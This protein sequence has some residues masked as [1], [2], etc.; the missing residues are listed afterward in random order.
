MIAI[1]TIFASISI[2]LLITPFVQH[3]GWQLGCVD[4]PG[5]RKTHQAP[6]VRIG[7]VAICAGT[8]GALLVT[9]QIG[10]FNGLLPSE[11][12]PILGLILGGFGFFSVGIA[13]DYLNLHP[14]IR[15]L[16]QA[17]I[18]TVVWTMGVQIDYLPIPIV[19][20]VATGLFG[21]PIT[22]LWLAGMANAIN[23]MDGLD[24]LA[25]GISAIVALTL[26]LCCFQFHHDA[27]ALIALAL[28]GAT[29]GFLRYN[30]NP[31]QIYMGDGGSYF[32]GF[33]LAGI[34]TVGFMQTDALTM[35][36]VPYIALAVPVLDMIFVIIARLIDGKSP[37]FA[38]LRHLHHR[39][40]QAGLSQQAVVWLIYGI[41]LCTALATIAVPMNSFGWMIGASTLLVLCLTNWRPGVPLTIIPQ[42]R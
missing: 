36:L 18:S 31:A 26:A 39:W 32:L 13:D 17:M 11:I 37:L 25:A 22:F 33:M 41:T 35:T 19:G 1:I 40:L 23:W 16:L 29:L 21:L 6:I 20:T 34:S 2:V 24:G 8:L 5:G 28:V 4:Q 38:D 27:I 9:W 30:S 7:G 42:H 3:L 12:L 15:L 10:G 14:L